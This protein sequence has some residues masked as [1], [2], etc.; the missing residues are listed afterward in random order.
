MPSETCSARNE[1]DNSSASVLS[2]LSHHERS[3]RPL[4]VNP[5]EYEFHENTFLRLHDKH[6]EYTATNSY[7]KNVIIFHITITAL[8]YCQNYKDFAIYVVQSAK[9]EMKNDV[10]ICWVTQGQCYN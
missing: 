4:H 8:L 3:T 6:L 7:F 5:Q 2:N 1:A 9:G 10:G